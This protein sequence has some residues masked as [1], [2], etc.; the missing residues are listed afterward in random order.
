MPTA[1]K[2][3]ETSNVR[4]KPKPKDLRGLQIPKLSILSAKKKV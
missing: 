4:V 2:V 1:F 3:V